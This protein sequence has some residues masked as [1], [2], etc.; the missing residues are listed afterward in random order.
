MQGSFQANLTYSRNM[1]GSLDR[2]ACRRQ[3]SGH[4]PSLL[5]G[6]NS[7]RCRL[8]HGL[9]TEVEY[10]RWRT[11]PCLLGGMDSRDSSSTMAYGG[12]WTT[13]NAAAD[14]GRYKTAKQP[15]GHI[16]RR[17][18]GIDYHWA[19]GYPNCR[20]MVESRGPQD[21]SPDKKSRVYLHD[22]QQSR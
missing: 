2:A 14:L 19:H 8:L 17:G 13:R 18:R 21:P 1:P 15:T 16:R 12:R 4:L 11:P 3:S 10:R 20:D 22:K 5:E 7:R 9:P 6:M